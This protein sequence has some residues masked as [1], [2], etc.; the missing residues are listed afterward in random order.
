MTQ[1]DLDRSQEH[2]GR[3]DLVVVIR[4]VRRRWRMKLALRGAAIAVACIAVALVLSAMTLQWMR[5]SA[6]SILAFRIVL[7]GAIAVVGYVFLARP[8][9]RRVT[10]EQVALYLEEHEPSL[11][12]AIISA[13]EAEHEGVSSQSPALVR[14]LVA[15]SL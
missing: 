6:E 14:K 3:S 1:Q 8:L 10:D 12:A 7:A 2:G 15:T 11:E 9:L 13:V 5:F 4:E